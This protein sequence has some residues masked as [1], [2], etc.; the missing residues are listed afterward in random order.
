MVLKDFL[1]I[2]GEPGLFKFIAQGKNSIIVEHLETKKRSSAYGSAKVSSLEDIAI[3]TE[4]ED[5]P[6]GKVFDIIFEKTNGG[7]AIDTKADGNKLKAWFEEILPDYS[8]DKVYVSDMKKIA[9]WYNILHKLDMLHKEEPEAEAKDNTEAASPT[10]A[11]P[12]EEKKK[13]PR[14]RKAE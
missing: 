1:A 8:R 10:E 5:V 9:L 3:F 13:S 14:K 2:S 4:K 12:V 7:T 6:L 11:A